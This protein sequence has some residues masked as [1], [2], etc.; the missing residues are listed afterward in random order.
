MP[1][2]IDVET[3]SVRAGQCADTREMRLFGFVV[4]V[5]GPCTCPHDTSVAVLRIAPLTL[6]AH[7]A[8]GRYGRYPV[9]LSSGTNADS[10]PSQTSF[11][12]PGLLCN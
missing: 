7:K 3:H 4:G 9:S 2:Q 10:L 8:D 11:K 12:T 1:S 6:L 5:A